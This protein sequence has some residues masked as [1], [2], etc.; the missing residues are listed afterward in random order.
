MGKW[1]KSVEVT[2]TQISKKDHG[3]MENQA[4]GIKIL[5]T[6]KMPIMR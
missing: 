1:G 5:N 6:L 2:S 4:Y 3:K